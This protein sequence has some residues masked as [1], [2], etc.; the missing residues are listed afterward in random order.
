MKIDGK[1]LTIEDVQKVA[2]E[3]EKVE[4]DENAKKKIE[5]SS[6]LVQKL[7]EEKQALY[8]ITTGIGEFSKIKISEEQ[9]NILQKKIIYSHAAGVGN[10]LPEDVVRAMMLLRANTIATGYTGVRLSTLQTLVDMLNKNVIPV[11]YEKGS[12]GASGDLSPLSQMAEVIIGEG[13]AIYEGKKMKGEDAL[14]KAGIK[15][16][17]LTYKEGLGLINGSQMSTAIAALVVYDA[18]RVLK[19][20]QIASAMTIDVLK[21]VMKAF[22]E[23][24]HKVRPFSGQN[25]VASNIRALVQDSEI[26]ADKTSKVQDGYSLRCTAQIIGP[27]LDAL[28]YVK[29]QILIEMNSACDNPLFFPEYG[30]SLTGGN[31]H[32]Q[33][34]SLAMD[35]LGIALTFV[36]GLSE[37]HINRLLNPTLSGLP[38]FLIENKGLNSGLMVAQYTAAALVSENKVLSHPASVDSISL[39][40]DQEDYVSMAPIAARKTREILE[41]LIHVIAIEMLAAA[42][43][44]EF[45]FPKRPGKG[46]YIAYKKIRESVDK[47]TEDRPLYPD[48]KKIVKLIKENIILESCEKEIGKLKTS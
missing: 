48:I 22:D 1:S 19:N 8:G 20:V 12:V 32:G 41:N 24:L 30:I 31:F 43:A 35:F 38:D 47:L 5:A 11:V 21:S 13:E 44:M 28:K 39:S 6:T 37:R 14:K 34:I 26:L 16:V 18:E 29:D 10:P 46:T 2:R 25:I 42:Q 17:K 27:A 9:S 4:I 7:V 36:A 40:A 15:P 33:P 23:R 45:R 3:Y